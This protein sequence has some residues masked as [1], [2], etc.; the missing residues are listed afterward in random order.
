MQQDKGNAQA[1]TGLTKIA[2][3]YADWTQ[4]ALDNNKRD[5]AQNYLARL[6]QVAP[7]SPKLAAL[8]AQLQEPK[9]GPA[10]EVFRDRL[11]DGSSGPEMVWI[12]EGRFEM[13]DIQ[14]GGYKNEKPVHWVSVKK[15]A[16]GRYEITFAEYDKFATATGREKPNDSGWGRGNRPRINGI[17]LRCHGLMLNG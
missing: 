8:E 3:R 7:H 14:G 16:M 10:G 1:L 5:K 12:P 15:F 11:K 6:R 2:N 9:P 4:K 13:G 17:G